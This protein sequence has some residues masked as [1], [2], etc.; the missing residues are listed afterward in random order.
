MNLKLG[1]TLVCSLATLAAAAG[2]MP[3]QALPIPAADSSGTNDTNV[4]KVPGPQFTNSVGMEL[5]RISG[6]SWAGKFEVTQKEY[7]KI[8]GSN[9]SAFP[10]DKLPVD[11]VSWNDA[12][13]FCRKLTEYDIKEKKLPEGYFY[14][15]PTE[16]EWESFAAS[17]ALDDAVTSFGGS[18][19]GTSPVGSLRPN[20]QGLYDVRG[21]V[22]EFCL[23]DPSQPYRILRGGSWQDFIEINLRSEFRYYCQ[24][25]ERK[26]TFGFRCVL[27]AGPGAAGN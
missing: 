10:G 26:N 16:G 3:V 2:E 12:V 19:G 23:T 13:E 7:Q 21:N 4:A 8:T 5:V 15:L 18:R 20:A 27:K 24:P 22:M 11:S 14:T 25:D 1:L 17:A 9:P 6:G